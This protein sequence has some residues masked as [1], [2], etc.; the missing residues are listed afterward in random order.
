MRSFAMLTL[1][2]WARRVEAAFQATVLPPQFRL[3]FDVESLAKADSETLYSALLRG[4]QGG[5]QPQRLPARR[6]AGRAAPIRAPTASS[7]RRQAADR[8]MRAPTSRRR[9]RRP[10]TA[11]ARRSLASMSGADP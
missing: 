3:R 9:R 1:G 7:H 10:T 6:P 8:L 2:P 11:T 4:R 5:W